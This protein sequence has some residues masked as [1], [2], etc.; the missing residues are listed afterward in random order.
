M[1]ELAE[2]ITTQRDRFAVDDGNIFAL[3]FAKVTRRWAFLHIIRVRY[4]EASNAFIENAEVFRASIR[5]GGPHQMTAEPMM[6]QSQGQHLGTLVHLEIEAYYLF[7]KILLDEIAHAIENYF[8]PVRGIAID[9]H[10]DFC[11][12]ILKYASAKDL[13]I[14]EDFEKAISDIRRQISD[15]RDA[16]IAHE[17]SPRAIKGMT[18]DATRQVM[19]ATTRL[20]PKPTDKQ[21]NSESVGSLT[22]MLEG[23]VDRVLAF[24]ET[25]QLKARFKIG[26]SKCNA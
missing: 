24:V 9:S 5:P 6:L 17:K 19:L 23:Y 8:G 26:Q 18:W 11:K 2:F 1:R 20:Y 13:T 3:S 25:N 16:Q 22:A 12:R 21:V 10:D 7:A 15:F 4:D 14:P